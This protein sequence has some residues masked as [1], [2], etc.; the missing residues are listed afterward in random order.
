MPLPREAARRRPV[1]ADMGAIVPA[2]VWPPLQPR[3][4]P[5]GDR[6]V[7]TQEE[8]QVLVIVGQVSAFLPAVLWRQAAAERAALWAPVLPGRGLARAKGPRTL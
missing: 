2:Q 4:H 6:G 3:S 1:L 7:L 5:W 8:V